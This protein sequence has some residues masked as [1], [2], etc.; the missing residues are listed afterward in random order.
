MDASSLET[1]LD[2]VKAQ[3]VLSAYECEEDETPRAEVELRNVGSANLV[4][5]SGR[6]L[7]AS[8]LEPLS[9]ASVGGFSGW[10]AGVGVVVRLAPGDTT[11]LPVLL[12]AHQGG[13]DVRAALPP[14]RFLA[15]VRVPI[16]TMRANDSGY[17]TNYVGAPLVEI[18]IVPKVT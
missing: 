12:G 6:P 9:R 14:G 18:R 10:I 15:Q 3:F 2:S 16:H 17:D 8:L 4:F 11:R 1:L 7:S 13:P 5:H